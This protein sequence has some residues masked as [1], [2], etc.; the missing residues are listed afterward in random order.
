MRG[1]HRTPHLSF[2][3]DRSIPA[4]AGE[5][6]APAQLA[7]GRRV[8]PRR[9]GGTD[10]QLVRRA[11]QQGLSPQVRG[12]PPGRAGRLDEEG[13]IPAGAGE[14]AAYTANIT[15]HKVY[16]RRCGGTRVRGY[17]REVDWGTWKPG[18]KSPLKCMM[19][20]RYYRFLH[21]GDVLHEIDVD[22]MVR[23]VNGVDQLEAQRQAL[24]I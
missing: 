12:N 18:E 16:P 11:I 2:I 24:G 6:P 13:S 4:G 1:N 7:R 10:Q 21:D 15:I 19:A 23:I 9:C 3:R 5:P 14:P 20:V 8:Y 17:V 22:N